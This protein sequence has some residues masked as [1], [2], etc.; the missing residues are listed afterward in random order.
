MVGLIED[1]RARHHAVL[2]EGGRRDPAARRAGRRT[3]RL[4]VP[5]GGPR[6]QG[7]ARRPGW[8]TRAK[9]RLHDAVRALIRAGLVRSAHDCSEG[10]LAVALAECCVSGR[11]YRLGATVTLETTTEVRADV[12]L[13]N[14]SQSPRGG[15]GRGGRMWMP[16]SALLATRGV[17]ARN[18][19]GRRE[20]TGHRDRTRQVTRLAG[21]GI[22][23]RLAR[24]PSA[25]A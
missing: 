14:E 12:V 5:G 13:F 23:P 6:P 18:R 22:A 11:Q 16:R 2:Q 15:L 7:R 21:G 17:P 25:I 3:G 19:H 8:T 24:T 1:E 4:A 10:G 9:S 20:G